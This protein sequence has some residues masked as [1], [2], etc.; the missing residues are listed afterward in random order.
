MPTVSIM[1]ETSFII[2]KE[3]W[4]VIEYD[5]TSVPGVMYLSV[6]EEKINTMYD[7]MNNNIVDYSNGVPSINYI[8]ML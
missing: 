4:R 6:G 7:D 3:S 1:R 5:Y 8:K 2:E